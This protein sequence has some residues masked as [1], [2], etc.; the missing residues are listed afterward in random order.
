MFLRFWLGNSL[1]NE[2]NAELY[3]DRVFQDSMAKEPFF[4]R[5]KNSNPPSE[6]SKDIYILKMAKEAVCVQKTKSV[7]YKWSFFVQCRHL[8]SEDEGDVYL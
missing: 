7:D 8:A 5:K 1:D 3:G 4:W 2:L 6:S